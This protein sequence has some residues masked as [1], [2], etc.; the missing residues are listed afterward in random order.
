MA[1]IKPPHEITKYIGSGHNRPHFGGYTIALVHS[2]ARLGT[3]L[4]FHNEEVTTPSSA[5]IIEDPQE[6][7]H[8][9]SAGYYFLVFILHGLSDKI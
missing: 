4:N 7:H 3:L 2:E 6:A 1:R 5:G 9:S 8:I